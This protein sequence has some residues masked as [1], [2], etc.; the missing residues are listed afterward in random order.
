MEYTA[1]LPASDTL[2][3]HDALFEAGHVEPDERRLERVAGQAPR[4]DPM[5]T[6]AAPSELAAA[7]HWGDERDDAPAPRPA[8]SPEC[9]RRIAA[10]MAMAAHYSIERVP[11]DAGDG[12][13]AVDMRF[14]VRVPP[15]LPFLRAQQEVG[16]N[17]NEHDLSVVSMGVDAATNDDDP[18]GHFAISLGFRCQ[19]RPNRPLWKKCS[20]CQ[21]DCGTTGGACCFRHR[22]KLCGTAGERIECN[23]FLLC[24]PSCCGG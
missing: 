7:L 15:D 24:E 12:A 22:G 14:R 2:V 6:P 20:E 10:F 17:A 3:L 5:P 9:E 8:P 18:D 16:V 19:G 23:A 11:L 4:C 13:D 1:E 21:P